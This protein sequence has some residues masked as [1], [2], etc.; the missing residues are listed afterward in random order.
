MSTNE[1]TIRALLERLA[2]ADQRAADYSEWLRKAHKRETRAWAEAER[3]AAENDLLRAA[4][5]EQA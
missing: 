5:K 1:P 2:D 3:L 4:A